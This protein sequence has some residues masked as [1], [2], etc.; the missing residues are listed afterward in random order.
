MRSVC[1]LYR[2]VNLAKQF[3]VQ[4]RLSSFGKE[5]THFGFKTVPS[6]EKAKLV[7]QVFSKVA[8]RYDTMND[9]MSGGLHRLWKDHLVSTLGPVRGTTI[10]DLAGGTGDVTFRI[11]EALKRSP[12]TDSSEQTRVLVCDINA[13]MLSEGRRRAL[14]R[15][16]SVDGVTL[17][18]VQADA[19]ALPFADGS[20][21]AITIAFG[22]RNVTRTLV[23]LR[24]ANRVL[25]RGGRFLCMEFSQVRNSAIRQAYDAYSF[26]IIPGLGQLVTGDA[27][28]YSY[29][30]ESIRRFPDQE[31]LADL[32]RQAGMVEVGHDDL[33]GGVVAV[34]SGFKP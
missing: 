20:V 22:L 13:Q 27:Q 16:I 15:G 24:E 21:D 5:T 11:L 12:T 29:L 8:S 14:E 9:L 17:D 18:F 1:G 34:H 7:E 4:R 19:E 31:A 2:C 10:I 25:R 3:S 6:D 26:S 32:M 28:P 30:V 23:A 33:L